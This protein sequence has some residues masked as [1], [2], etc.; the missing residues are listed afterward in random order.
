VGIANCFAYGNHICYGQH[1]YVLTE[2][3]TCM[4]R[5]FAQKTVNMS[6]YLST[7]VL[8]AVFKVNLG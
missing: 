3:S 1:Y 4:M 8:V 7:C 5:N 2:Y 6:D